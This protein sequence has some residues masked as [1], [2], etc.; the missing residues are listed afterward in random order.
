MISIFKMSVAAEK[1]KNQYFMC[2]KNR[3]KYLCYWDEIL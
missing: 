1:L 2:N 3:I